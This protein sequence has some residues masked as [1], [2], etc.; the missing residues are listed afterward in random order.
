[1]VIVDTSMWIEFFNKK[2]S[3]HGQT[4]QRLIETDLAVLVGPVL[5]ELLQGAR[6]PAETNTLGN[7]LQI[8]P[9]YDI[10]KSTWVDSG[11]RSRELR[12]RGITIPMTDILIASLAE[13]QHCLIATLDRHF[14]V[15]PKLLYQTN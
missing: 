15:F 1:M 2:D 6:T 10:Q 3:P 11:K 12:S 4:V 5:F 14:E 13:K 9:Y 8:L 7:A